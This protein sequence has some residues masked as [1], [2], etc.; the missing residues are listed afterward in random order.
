MET[1]N[2]IIFLI[3]IISIT[4]SPL[5]AQSADSLIKRGLQAE[6]DHNTEA[7][8]E[9]Y[10]RAIEVD[11]HNTEALWRASRAL[12]TQ[13]GRS[14]DK[15]IQATRAAEANALASKAIQLDPASTHARLA[16]VIALG[17]AAASAPNPAEKLTNAKV[18]HREIRMM[19]SYDST[20]APA[21]YVLGKWHLDLAKLNWA[22]R[23]A[24]NVLFGGIPKGASLDESIRCFDKAIQLE[25]DFLLFHYGKASALYEAGRF[26]EVVLVLEHAL[27][28]ATT[29]PDDII[30]RQNCVRLLE[31]SKHR[32]IRI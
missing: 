30:R 17:I 24:C 27:Q 5:R 13:A 15:G 3:A 12:S 1:P 16:R 31:E 20:F 6:N 19:L 4:V 28:L 8:L 7:A 21:Y 23:L 11:Q 22:E 14:R 18:I 29:H 10:K 26:T 32:S 9:L 25:P 2:R